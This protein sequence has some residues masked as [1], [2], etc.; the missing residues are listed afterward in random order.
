MQRDFTGMGRH[1]LPQPAGIGLRGQERRLGAA[2]PQRAGG[3]RSDGSYL[4]PSQIG[5]G[6]SE[7]RQFFLQSAHRLR[8]RQQQPRDAAQVA[9]RRVQAGT[10]RRRSEM[11]QGDFEHLGVK[12][13]NPFTGDIL[14]K[15][16]AFVTATTYRGAVDPAGPEWYDGWTNYVDD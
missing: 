1:L 5:K 6:A 14:T 10:V 16:G 15:A 13:L 9:Q 7:G 11:D 8:T 12:L 2:L 4:D 3:P